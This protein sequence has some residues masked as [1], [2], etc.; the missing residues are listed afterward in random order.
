MH[1]N[2]LGTQDS[3]HLPP[4]S[5]RSFP[6]A[7]ATDSGGGGNGGG[8]GCR[9]SWQPTQPIDYSVEWSQLVCGI[10]FFWALNQ[11]WPTRGSCQESAASPRFSQKILRRS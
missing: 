1:H 7:A 3:S 4:P 8:N 2:K 10:L 6:A 11:P 9:P 5:L